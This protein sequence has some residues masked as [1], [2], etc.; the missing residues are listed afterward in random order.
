[1][2]RREQA[3]IE[4]ESVLEE[5]RLRLLRIMGPA[6]ASAP[7]LRI[8]AASDPVIDPQPIGDLE[9][10]LQL[11]L[12][13]RSDLD[14]AK[15]RL[16]QDRLETILTRNGLLPR[17]DLFISLGKTGFAD[18]FSDSF[19]ELEGSTYDLTAGVRLSHFLGNREAEARNLAARAARG[20]G[21][22]AVRNLEELIV[23]D[24]RLAAN[25]VERTRQQ[26]AAS[27]VTRELQE[28]SLTAEKER[29]DVGAS[30]SLLVAQAQR[31][32]LASRIVEVEA[33]VNYRI[34]LVGLYL[35]EGS[36]LDRRGVRFD[37]EEA[38]RI[39]Q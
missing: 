9:D 24:V 1:M 10:R 32:Y 7:G 18:T 35:A 38:A 19:R 31:D 23:L 8:K 29:F 5:R 34:A 14:E 20:Q 30:T 12:R 27:R 2:A 6:F 28:K 37:I 15:L 21:E 13:S 4:A 25:E 11:A 16:M 36:L 39:F 22:E 26:I 3:L 33:V 17:L